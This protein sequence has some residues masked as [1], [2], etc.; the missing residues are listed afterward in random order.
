MN[1]ATPFTPEC[2]EKMYLFFP[3]LSRDISRDIVS[4]AAGLSRNTCAMGLKWGKIGSQLAWYRESTPCGN[5]IGLENRP[6]RPESEQNR[7]SRLLPGHKTGHHVR[8]ARK[9]GS[10]A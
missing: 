9:L 8:L 7:D 6:F 3:G 5:R 10:W 1:L 4:R 2:R